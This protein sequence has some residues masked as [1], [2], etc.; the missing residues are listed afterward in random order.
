MLLHECSVVANQ[1]SEATTNWPLAIIYHYCTIYHKK[2]VQLLECLEEAQATPICW[3][4]MVPEVGIEPT[5][6]INPTGF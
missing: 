4:V 5:R 1:L 3:K 2:G 6:G